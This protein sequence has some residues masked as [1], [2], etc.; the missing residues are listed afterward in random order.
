MLTTTRTGSPRQRVSKYHVQET[1]GRVLISYLQ[2]PRTTG[3][4][5]WETEVWTK[6]VFGLTQQGSPY[7]FFMFYAFL[8]LNG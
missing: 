5:L 1:N 6:I 2:A 3:W 4:P 7:V 8:Q